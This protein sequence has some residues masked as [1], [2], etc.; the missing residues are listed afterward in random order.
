MKPLN[1]SLRGDSDED[2]ILRLLRPQDEEERH[3]E[4]GQAKMEMPQVRG[5]PNDPVRPHRF[6]T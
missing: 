1:L 2:G 5:F 6:E 4:R 3:D